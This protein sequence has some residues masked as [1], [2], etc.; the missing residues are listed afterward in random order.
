VSEDYDG[1][2]FVGIDLHRRRSVIVRQT[3]AGEQLSVVRIDNDPV[4]LGLEIA[5]AGPDPEVVLEATYGWY[6]AADVLVAAGARVHL[7]HPLGVKGFA[8]RRVKNDVRDAADLV[9]LLRMGRL[10][11]A[12]LAPPAVRELR[13][14]VRHRAKLVA[15]RSGLKAEVH[16]VLAKQGLLIAVSDLFGVGGRELLTRAPLDAPFRARADACC[17]LIDAFG[18]EIDLV[19]TQLG[20]RL[21]GHAGFHAIQRIPG[22]G[23]TLAAVFVAEIG[24]PGRFPTAAHLASWAGLTPR[25]RESDTKVH[26][27]SITKQGSTLVRWAAVEAAQ[28]I[29]ASAGWLVSNRARIV[30]RRGRNIATVAVARKLLTLV[31]YGLRDGHI[32]ALA[33]PEAA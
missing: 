22:V 1:G 13:E 10:P 5:K 19:A 32:R 30:E 31:Y 16:A 26:R 29:P 2:Q 11:E 6:W 14:L 25:H 27:G 23:P 15:L 7:A 21:A 3:A 33:R 12:Y 9:D 17:R 28:K 4:A 18:F 8:Y 20:G 24:E